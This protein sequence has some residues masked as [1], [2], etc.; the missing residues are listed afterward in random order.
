M[1]QEIDIRFLQVYNY[2]IPQTTYWKASD[3]AWDTL[4]THLRTMHIQL[5]QSKSCFYKRSGQNTGIFA[6]MH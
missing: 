4:D 5:Q 2:Y 1:Q 3:H 6:K